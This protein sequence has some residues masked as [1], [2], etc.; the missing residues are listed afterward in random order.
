MMKK[1]AFISGLFAFALFLGVTACNFGGN[2]A[3]TSATAATVAA[4]EPTPKPAANA[5]ATAGK[6]QQTAVFA[7]GCFWG[8]EAVYEHVKGVSDSR[9]GYAGGTAKTAKYDLVSGGDTGHAESVMV[10]F[11]PQQVSYKQLLKVFF[12]VVHDPTELN[13][14]GPDTGTQYRSAIFFTS[15]EQKAE[16]QSYIEEL[17]KAK[18]FS[19]PIVTQ[20][21][22]LDKFYDAESYH[23]DY[24]KHNPDEAYIVINDKPKVEALKKQFPD[25]YVEK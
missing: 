24:L 2:S 22:S 10:T 3:A 7:G 14:Q 23:Q 5:P 11:D 12:S 18:T 4:S 6:N 9:S 25:L 13:R 8:V 17:T 15:E 21:T 19:K 1:L 16:A 20:I